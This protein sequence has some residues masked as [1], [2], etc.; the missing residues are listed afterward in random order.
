MIVTSCTSIVS[1]G[2]DSSQLPPVSAARSTI[3]DPARIDST[4]SA[5]INRGAGFPGICAVVITRSMILDV[6]ADRRE[7]VELLFLRLRARVAARR[8]RRRR[9]ELVGDER[10]AEALHLLARGGSDVERRHDAAES[11]RGGDRLK[12]GDA[13]ADDEDL[14]R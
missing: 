8:F 12:S 2:F 3:T 4:I 11:A 6:R 13:G 5:V 1:P 10:R 14:G 7:R 9:R